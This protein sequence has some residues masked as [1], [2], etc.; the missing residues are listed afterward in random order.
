MRVNV[1]ASFDIPRQWA[2]FGLHAQF[3]RSVLIN[4]SKV[5]CK[6]YFCSIICRSLPG[7]FSYWFL[8]YI[9]HDVLIMCPLQSWSKFHRKKYVRLLLAKVSA[10]DIFIYRNERTFVL[11]IKK[12]YNSYFQIVFEIIESCG[13]LSRTSVDAG[14]GWFY[15]IRDKYLLSCNAL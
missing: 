10:S 2:V 11:Y 9:V 13:R 15:F 7:N 3:K 14:I 8:R 1:K 4:F 12:V 6:F 5:P